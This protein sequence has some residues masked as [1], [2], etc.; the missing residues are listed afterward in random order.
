MFCKNFKTFSR[1]FCEFSVTRYLSTS[2][3]NALSS[4]L[5]QSDAFAVLKTIR[6]TPMANVYSCKTVQYDLLFFETTYLRRLPCWRRLPCCARWFCLPSFALSQ[7]YG[8]TFSNKRFEET[9]FVSGQ[10]FGETILT[11]KDT[12][13]TRALYPDTAERP[14]YSALFTSSVHAI[15]IELHRTM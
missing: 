1:I 15:S 2:Q 5:L 4:S 10:C 11:I 13:A 14:H 3:S 7:V 12:K 6:V 8:T 9:F